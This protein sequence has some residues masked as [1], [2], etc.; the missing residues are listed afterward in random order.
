MTMYIKF[1]ITGSLGN[2]LTYESIGRIQIFDGINEIPLDNTNIVYHNFIKRISASDLDAIFTSEAATPYNTPN[3]EGIIIVKLPTNIS[4]P[5]TIK[6]TSYINSGGGNKVSVSHS[7][8]NLKYENIGEV[9]FSSVSE[10]K[11]I[12]NI[13]I[14]KNKIL[15]SSTGGDIVSP[16]NDG[17]N[18]IL[19]YIPSQDEQS[20]LNHGIDGGTPINPQLKYSHAK[21]INNTSTP[22]GNGKVFEQPIDK[23][24]KSLNVK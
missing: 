15:I 3:N 23:Y 16:E 7:Y 10:E 18:D 6:L 17:T 11:E 4:H 21:Y 12:S 20:F 19:K 14:F 13:L 24:I 22:L 9:I 5:L 1:A 8:D 2:S